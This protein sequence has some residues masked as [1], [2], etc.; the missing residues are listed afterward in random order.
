MI[1]R[2][3][4]M[5]LGSAAVAWPLAARAQQPRMP[6]I[7]FLNF[8]SPSRGLPTGVAFRQSLAE[9]G[10]VVGTT[11]AME[12]RWANYQNPLLPR[13]AAE[14]VDRQVD[15]I[16]TTGS[17]YAVLAMKA[18]TSTIPIV[19]M[20][21]S[22]PVK[23]GMVSSLSRPGGNVTGVHVY[24][25]ELAAKR[26]ELLREL[27]PQ[28]TRIGYL[29]GPSES[30]VFDEMKSDMLEAGRA[31]G[32]EIVVLEVRNLN[33][34]AAFATLVEQRAAALIVGN[35]TIFANAA[36][37]G[38]IL[39]LAARH[40]IPAIYARREDAVS[41]GLMSY[42]AD[43]VAAFRLLGNYAGRILKGAKPADLPVQQSTKFD[44]FINRKT[45]KALG[46]SIPRIL[47]ATATELID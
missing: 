42:D 37:R 15:V 40:K 22:D 33:F 46:L 45:A 12:L 34:E 13:L 7:G 36:N 8:G 3:L 35:Y 29:S 6:V 26:L 17:P 10:Y 25:T 28:A 24:S 4:I 38:K 1:R 5:L 2:Q 18:A 19:F 14:L 9:A 23:H 27:V 11:M 41:G 31:L 30:P 44:L 20:T 21:G 16:V 47:L 43:S 32:R 39:E